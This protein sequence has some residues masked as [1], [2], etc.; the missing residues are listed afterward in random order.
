[1]AANDIHCDQDNIKLSF[2]H[3]NRLF[4]AIYLKIKCSQLSSFSKRESF[5]FPYR[6]EFGR[7]GGEG[8]IK[9][10]LKNF[11]SSLLSVGQNNLWQII[12]CQSIEN[13][14]GHVLV[15]DIFCSVCD[16]YKWVDVWLISLWLKTASLK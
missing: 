10:T 2:K 15:S 11:L 8:V 14:N 12:L 5:C 7:W 1:M 3:K 16:I 6:H 9:N 4:L 13:F